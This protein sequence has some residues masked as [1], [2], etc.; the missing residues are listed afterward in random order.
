MTQQGYPPSQSG[1]PDRSPHRGPGE[2]DTE[3]DERDP[4]WAGLSISPRRARTREPAPG[5]GADKDGR[6][7]GG[8]QAPRSRAAISRARRTRRTRSYIWGGAALAVLVIAGA[9]SIPLLG[10]HPARHRAARDGIVTTFLPGEYRAA[11]DTC[12]AVTSATLGTYLPGKRRVL[13]P[14]SLEGR[15]ESQCDWSVDKPP[16]YRL[17]DVTARAYAPSGLASGD[18]SATFAAGDAYRAA[19]QTKEHPPKATHLPKAQVTPV[20]GIGNAGFAALQEPSA[21][22]DT[23]DVVTVVVR[24]RNVLVTVVFDGLAHSRTHH[25]GPVS[26]AQLRAGAVAA[27]REVLAR[28]H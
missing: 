5:R 26:A 22:G 8:G 23:T 13:S 4:P 12:T 2:Q 15:A 21:G 1:R 18:G 25:Y 10:G 7:D 11:P 20:H 14:H 19:L 9:L 17:L 16:I 28:L 27:A 6:H 24:E 3:S